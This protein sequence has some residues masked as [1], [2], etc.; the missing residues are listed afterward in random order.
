MIAAIT[1]HTKGFRPL[2]ERNGLVPLIA[3]K[4]KKFLDSNYNISLKWI[5]VN[6]KKQYH[7]KKSAC[8]NHC[9]KE[10]EFCKMR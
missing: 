3:Q 9:H 7:Q 5:N 8:R 1:E 10:F 4:Q 6:G 2:R